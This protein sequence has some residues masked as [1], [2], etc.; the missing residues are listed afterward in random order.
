[1]FEEITE[2]RGGQVVECFVGGQECFE[3]DSLFDR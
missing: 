1:M 3:V 2:V